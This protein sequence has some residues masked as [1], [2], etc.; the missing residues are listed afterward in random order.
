VISAKRFVCCHDNGEPVLYNLSFAP[1]AQL[2]R[3]P[4][5]EPGGREFESLRARQLIEKPA[6]AGFF[7]PGKTRIPDEI[8]KLFDGIARCDAEHRVAAAPKGPGAG[9]KRI[10]AKGPM[11]PWPADRARQDGEPGFRAKQESEATKAPSNPSG[12]AKCKEFGLASLRPEKE[13]DVWHHHA[14]FVARVAEKHTERRQPQLENIRSAGRKE[15]HAIFPALQ[16]NNN[17]CTAGTLPAI[18]AELFART[19]VI[20]ARENLAASEYC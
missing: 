17:E 4:G 11:D 2:D 15:R 5:Y 7:A 1:V 12:R 16:A 20:A 10:I 19:D 8:K 13:E 9:A 14:T 6:R 18:P 3:V